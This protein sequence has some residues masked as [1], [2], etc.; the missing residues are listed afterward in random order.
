[1]GD[2]DVLIIVGGVDNSQR[3]RELRLAIKQFGQAKLIICGDVETEDIESQIKKCE[4]MLFKCKC[5]EL[6]VDPC[7]DYIEEFEPYEHTYNPPTLVHKTS[8]I[9]RKPHRHLRL[10]KNRGLHWDK[11]LRL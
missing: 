6:N 9:N 3:I 10:A 7:I 5:Y 4:K 1:M 8:Q 11:K 2:N